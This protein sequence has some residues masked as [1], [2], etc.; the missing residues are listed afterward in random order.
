MISPEDNDLLCRVEGDAPMGRIMRRHWIP[1]CLS[2]EVAEPDGAPLAVRLLGEDFVV[3]RDSAGRLGVLDG[4]CPHRRAALVFGRNEEC[5]L[6]CLYH[7]W[8]FDVEGNVLDMS[9]EPPDSRMR[10][11]LKHKAYPVRE[12]GGFVWVYLGPAAEQPEFQAP[13]WAP[14]AT[15]RVSIVRMQIRCNWAQVLEGAIDSAHSS[16]LHSTDMPSAPVSGAKATETV[17]PRP[18]TDKSP[19]LQ[20]QLDDWG[21][22]YAAI[23]RPIHNPEAND[24]VRITVFIAPFTVLIPPN[25][26]YNLAQAIIPVDDTHT[27]F[28]F[29]AWHETDGIDQD[30]WRAFCAAVP[31]VD[32]GADWL[33]IRSLGNRY[34][35]DRSVMRA[36]NFTGIKGIPNQDMAMW[37]SMGPIGDRSKEK[38]GAS[39]LAVV[40]FRRQMV[41]A[42]RAVAAGKPA[43]GTGAGRIAPASLRSFEGVVPKGTDW[44][45]LGAG[46]AT[47]A[48]A[49]AEP[50][51]A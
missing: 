35:Q 46:P 19:R 42:A 24:Y 13:A 11:R 14:T 20:V 31:G 39:D 50:A 30:A 47:T 45:R 18:S 10:E 49:S 4:L 6:R 36:G 44:R 17:W 8:K 3:F 22:R 2:E 41:A 34:Q 28:N 51:A 33:P 26:R 1:A 37:E 43:I 48:A 25:D 16:S 15:T 29:I 27:T 7:G 12:A 40:Q 9:S 32:L 23:R 21:F 5:G 38:L